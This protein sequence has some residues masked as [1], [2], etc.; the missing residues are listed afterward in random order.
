MHYNSGSSWHILHLHV[1]A[2][3]HFADIF[4]NSPE[5]LIQHRY[6][7]P[8]HRMFGSLVCGTT[9][10]K[11]DVFYGLGNHHDNNMWPFDVRDVVFSTLGLVDT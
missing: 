6:S 11:C 4:K 10:I 1:A 5:C 8:W 2:R 7:T 9:V 3:D